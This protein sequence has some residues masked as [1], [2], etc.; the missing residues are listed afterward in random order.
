[1]YVRYQ[2]QKNVPT[3]SDVSRY[4]ERG[5]AIPLSHLTKPVG[6][7]LAVPAI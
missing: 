4:Q 6:Y 5:V 7:G 1:M 3:Q 2:N